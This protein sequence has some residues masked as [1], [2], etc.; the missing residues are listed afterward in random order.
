MTRLNLECFDAL[1]HRNRYPL[2]GRSR[3]AGRHRHA[4]DLWAPAEIRDLCRRGVCEDR[5]RKDF[6]F[7][8]RRRG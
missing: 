8:G 7:L 4:S 5:I 1:T 6:C 2:A 3:V